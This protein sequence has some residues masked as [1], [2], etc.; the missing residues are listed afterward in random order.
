MVLM[1]P[2]RRLYHAGV[3]NILVATAPL[4]GP[5]PHAVLLTS[6]MAAVGTLHLHKDP[7]AF[8]K[9][10]LCMTSQAASLLLGMNRTLTH[11]SFLCCHLIDSTTVKA[12]VSRFLHLIL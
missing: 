8:Y 1:Y 6:F 3:V 7:E 10:L 4:L 2:F 11:S 5:Q 12:A 9:K